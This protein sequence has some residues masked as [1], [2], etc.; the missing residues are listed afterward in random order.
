MASWL[1]SL[2]HQNHLGFVTISISTNINLNRSV[3]RCL[4][5]F[6][7]VT[8]TMKMYYQLQLLE[9]LNEAKTT[10]GDGRSTMT[11]RTVAPPKMALA[12]TT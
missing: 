3:I 10:Y 6:T 4:S 7:N 8:I 1:G 2:V 5:T 9:G 12:V 11:R